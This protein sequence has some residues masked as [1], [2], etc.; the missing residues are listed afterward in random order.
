MHAPSGYPWSAN[1]LAIMIAVE[2]RGGT[3]ANSRYV[4]VKGHVSASETLRL[5]VYIGHMST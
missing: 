3:T 5:A 4:E 2:V 1:G